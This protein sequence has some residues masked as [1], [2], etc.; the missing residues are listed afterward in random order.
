VT[1]E[2]IKIVD[3][4][5]GGDYTTL[6]AALTANAQD[7]TATDKI[8]H[9]KCRR[10]SGGGQDTSIN[11]SSNQFAG[12]TTD[13]TRYVFIEGDPLTGN[14]A[15]PLWSN[16]KYTLYQG[17]NWNQFGIPGGFNFIIQGLQVYCDGFIAGFIGG[18]G[19][20][21]VGSTAIVNNCFIY[22]PNP[23][24]T[25][26][27]PSA[28][29]WSDVRSILTITNTIVVGFYQGDTSSGNAGK[30]F[31]GGNCIFRNCL[32]YNCDMGFNCGGSGVATNCIAVNSSV[33]ISGTMAG[34][35][36]ATTGQVNNCVSSDTTATSFGGAG[37]KANQVPIFVNVA[38]LDF[39]LSPSD[40]VAQ[41]A[42]T[43]L[44]AYFTTDMDG[45]TITSWS[46]GADAQ[47]GGGTTY[48]D[49]HG[50]AAGTSSASS[51]D[52]P[53]L[54]GA[55]TASGL[56]SATATGD[57]ILD[58]SGSA[59]GTSAASSG[60]SPILDGAGTAAGASLAQAGDD[61]IL[62]GSGSASGTST[63]TVGIDGFADGSGSATGASTATGK[64][65]DAG[66][67]SPNPQS[68][69]WRRVAPVQKSRIVTLKT[70]PKRVVTPIQH[71]RL[72]TVAAPA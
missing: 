32:A 20:S 10:G 34:F 56:G 15:T 41:G 18:P 47:V 14:N 1:T 48:A 7:L 45:D 55:G 72:V 8:L 9:I 57:E 67:A 70:M 16:T 13:A 40:T 53:L 23:S 66:A 58:G 5:G 12:Y 3:T 28:F 65:D 64:L 50:T 31:D 27:G 42:G 30:A 59:A 62:D 33:I 29:G 22:K 54:D 60:D 21:S 43:N 63:V 2:V 46:M 44:S 6:L 49:G 19:Y 25:Y 69:R 52:A 4:A 24:S 38:G 39:H 35:Y 51:G 11:G 71:S 36:Y 68:P 26:G 17:G 61:E 37:N